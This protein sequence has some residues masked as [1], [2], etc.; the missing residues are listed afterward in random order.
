MHAQLPTVTLI[1]GM[2]LDN[3][4]NDAAECQLAEASGGN[5]LSEGES[6]MS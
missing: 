3:I 4:S 5:K 2:L 6:M 1:V